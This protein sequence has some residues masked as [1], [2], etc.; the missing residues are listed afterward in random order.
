MGR[1]PP[2]I[3]A[4]VVVAVRETADGGPGFGGTY[5]LKVVEVGKLVGPD[6]NMEGVPLTF[7]M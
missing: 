7:T 4:L 5:R 2:L 3:V 1:C 6:P